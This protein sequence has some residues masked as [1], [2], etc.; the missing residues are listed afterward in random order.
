METGLDLHIKAAEAIKQA[1]R[2]IIDDTETHADYLADA[3]H[4]YAVATEDTH[5][6][7]ELLDLLKKTASKAMELRIQAIADAELYTQYKKQRD[8]QEDEEE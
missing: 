4:S 5:P 7:L 8:P 3:L 1:A 6:A 2:V